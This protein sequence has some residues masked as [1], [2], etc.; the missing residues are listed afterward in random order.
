[1]GAR[2]AALLAVIV[3]YLAAFVVPYLALPVLLWLGSPWAAAAAL[4]VGLNLLTRAALAVRL[5]HTLLSVILHPVAVIFLLLIGVNSFLW[6]RSGKI[7]WRG[8]TYAA[9]G[10]RS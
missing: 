7:R 8:R 2:P 10:D 3:L 9:R 6:T 1:L 5:D 4:G